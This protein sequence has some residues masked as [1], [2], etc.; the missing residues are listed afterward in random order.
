MNLAEKPFLPP[1]RLRLNTQGRLISKAYPR[2]S[3]S[4]RHNPRR[5]HRHNHPRSHLHNRQLLGRPT[6]PNLQYDQ[7]TLLD[8]A[9]RDSPWKNDCLI[10]TSSSSGSATHTTGSTT[11]PANGRR[12]ERVGFRSGLLH[13]NVLSVDGLLRC[14]EQIKNYVLIVVGD[15][16]KVFALVLDFVER[17]FHFNDL[18]KQMTFNKI[19]KH[20]LLGLRT[21]VAESAEEGADGLL[22]RV[23]R[24]TTNEDLAR[25][26]L[27]LLRIHPLSIDNVFTTAHDLDLKKVSGVAF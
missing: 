26:G 10:I 8:T 14:L 17:H 18:D 23:L 12:T 13:V 6:R 9:N 22:G 19:F 1:D 24:K 21:N 16:A 3:R 27:S 20:G 7:R 2:H 15:E 25:A 11:S 5:I 4:H